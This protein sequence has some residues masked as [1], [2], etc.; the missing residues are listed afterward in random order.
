MN[1]I[2]E[3]EI[4]CRE[5]ENQRSENQNMSQ[6]DLNGISQLQYEAW[7]KALNTVW[8]ILKET[9]SKEEMEKLTREQMQWIKEKEAAA[10]KAVIDAGG[11]SMAISAYGETAER[12]TRQRLEI[13]VPLITGETI[14]CTEEALPASFAEPV[15][16]DGYTYTPE[17]DSVPVKLT[18]TVENVQEGEAAW[19][20]ILSQKAQLPEPEQGKEYIIVTV[21]VTYEDG[22]LETLN[23]VE[24][25][26]ASLAAAR[27]HFNVPNENSNT[28]DV[29][30]NLANPI[31]GPDP[32]EGRFLTR[33][34]S[35]TGDVA[36][37]QEIGNKQPLYFEGY[38]QAISFE[39]H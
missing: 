27:V 18:M 19:K 6:A 29:T 32:F 37:L 23:F 21:K 33:G 2:Q 14:S 36:F 5:L 38:N 31:W 17:G 9:L 28:E 30:Y 24:N 7:D 15:T 13:L 25:Y 3:A 35:I 10:E 26:P 8:E 1:A 12:W 11:S 20:Q 4:A 39:I 22:E 34:D 16:F